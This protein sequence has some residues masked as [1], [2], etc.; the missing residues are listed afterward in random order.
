MES[1]CRRCGDFFRSRNM[2]TFSRLT[3]VVLGVA[4]GMIL[5]TYVVMTKRDTGFISIPGNLLM[6]L[7]ELAM[8]PLLLTNLVIVI[9]DL[10]KGFSKRI[11]LRSA[12]YCVLTTFL[13]MAIGLMLVLVVQPGLSHNA[14]ETAGGEKDFSSF[15]SFVDLMW[16]LVPESFIKSLFKQYSSKVV[17]GGIKEVNQ[18]TGLETITEQRW[19]RGFVDRPNTLGLV[20]WC[21]LY[22]LGLSLNTKEMSGRDP[23]VETLRSFNSSFTPVVKY[24]FLL[25]LAVVFMTANYVIEI[26]GNFGEIALQLTKF[27]G[28]VLCGHI[29]H[30]C[31]VLPLIYTVCVRRNPLPVILGV[32]PAMKRA[33]LISRSSAITLTSQCCEEENMVDK[34]ITSFLLQIRNDFNMDGTALYEV[35]AAVFITQLNHIDLHWNQLIVLCVTVAASNIGDEEVPATG[36]IITFFILNVIGVPWRNASVLFAVEWL[37][38]ASNTVVNVLGDC[39]CVSVVQHLSG[40][41]LE[42]VRGD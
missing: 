17:S 23:F 19:E 30:V 1:L 35:V 29:I 40:K 25:P 42:E 20:L 22:G 33:L 4:L 27:V 32:L 11:A 26:E 14:G 18:S 10:S 16:N 21:V 31:I 3:A 9:W 12:V 36:T 37:L 38:D 2:M 34:R 39:I 6:R 5:K 28:V 15:A 41:E 13:A 8:V 24:L 7:L